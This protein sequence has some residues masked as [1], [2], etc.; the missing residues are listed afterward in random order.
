MPTLNHC[1]FIGRLGRDPEGDKTLDG[2]RIAKFSLAIDQGKGKKAMWLNFV[3]WDKLAETV[4]K[5]ARKGMLVFVEG[6]LQ[7]NSYKDRKGIDRTSVEVI[8]SN[9]QFL[10]K[11]PRDEDETLPNGEENSSA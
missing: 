9:I 4:Q 5:Y 1:A 8:V 3:A 6:K 10:E 7:V 2:Q 11:L